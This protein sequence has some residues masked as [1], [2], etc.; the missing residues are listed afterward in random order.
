MYCQML[1][2]IKKEKKLLLRV[3]INVLR[4]YLGIWENY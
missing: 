4:F 3:N 1:I 2:Y